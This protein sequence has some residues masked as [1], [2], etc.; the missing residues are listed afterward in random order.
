MSLEKSDINAL[1]EIVFRTGMDL[2]FAEE[3]N[4]GERAAVG[5]LR[6]LRKSF[7]GI[8]VGKS[9]LNPVN[10]ELELNVLCAG[11]GGRKLDDFGKRFERLAQ[12]D[13]SL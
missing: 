11:F 1:G 5:L 12:V 8:I 9:F 3:M 13:E 2:P 7:V 10:G 4:L 6:D